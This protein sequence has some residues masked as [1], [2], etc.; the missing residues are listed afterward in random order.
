MFMLSLWSLLY[1]LVRCVH[2]SLHL[3]IYDSVAFHFLSLFVAWLFLLDLV[4]LMPELL[5]FF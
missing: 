1:F 2:V 5:Y 3:S 4:H